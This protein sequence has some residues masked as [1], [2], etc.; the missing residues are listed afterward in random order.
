MSKI[1]IDCASKTDISLFLE[2]VNRQLMKIRYH[3]K[4]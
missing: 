2:V 4:Y 3:L 1:S